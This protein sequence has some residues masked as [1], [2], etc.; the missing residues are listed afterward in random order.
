L[1]CSSFLENKVQVDQ[2]INN[3]KKEYRSR[4]DFLFCNIPQLEGLIRKPKSAFYLFIPISQNADGYKFCMDLLN[5]DKIAV[6]PGIA[7][8]KDF[9]SFLRVAFCGVFDDIKYGLKSIVSKV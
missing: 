9:S 1:G 6:T 7:F 8:G 4:I 5:E 2:A 3:V